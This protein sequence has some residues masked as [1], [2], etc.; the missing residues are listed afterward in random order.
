[1]FV[2]DLLLNRS[3]EVFEQDVDVSLMNHLRG[4]RAPL[5]MGPVTLGEVF[6]VMPFENNVVLLELDGQSL[7][8][9]ADFVAESANSML[10]PV[11]FQVTETGAENLRLNGKP[12]EMDKTY[13]LAVSD[14]MANGGSG[15]QMLK[16]KKSL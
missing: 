6:Q 11:S 1:M 4:L 5:N 15:F 2:C 10:W 7:E 14:Y 12:I 16:S 13:I 3:R 9:V 8:V